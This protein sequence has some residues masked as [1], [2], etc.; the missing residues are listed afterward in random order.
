[1]TGIYVHIPFCVQK[2]LYC[3]FPSYGGISSYQEDYVAALCREI[4]AGRSDYGGRT[5]DLFSRSG[6]RNYA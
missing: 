1:M 5:G 2:C 6:C 4:G 3:D